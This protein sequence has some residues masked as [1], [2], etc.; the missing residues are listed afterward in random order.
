[1]K[2]I[3]GG[4]ADYY[5]SDKNAEP[6]SAAGN[7]PSSVSSSRNGQVSVAVPSAASAAPMV[8]PIGLARVDQVFE[9]SPAYHSGIRVGDIILSVGS[10]DSLVARGNLTPIAA[11]IQANVNVSTRMWN[12]NERY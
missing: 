7:R 5:A 1:M 2:K 9:N 8:A 4:L 12:S 10:I 3:E 11:E 6:D